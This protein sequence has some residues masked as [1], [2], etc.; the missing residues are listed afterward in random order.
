M[1]YNNVAGKQWNV[2]M[3]F[4]LSWLVGWF[5]LVSIVNAGESQLQDLRFKTLPGDRLQLQFQFAGP[6]VTP[7]AFQTNNPARI[8]LDFPGVKSALNKKNIPINMGVVTHVNIVEGGGRSRVVIN[9]IDQAPYQIEPEGN[10]LLVTVENAGAMTSAATPNKTPSTDLLGQRIEKIDFRRGPNGEG[11]I[12][13]SLENPNTLVD[14]R[15]EGGKVIATFLNTTLPRKLAKKLDVTDF[16]TPVK[17]ISAFSD[18]KKTRLVII[19]AGGNYDYLSYQSNRLLTIEFRPLSR[20]EKEQIKK[21]KFP[22]TGQRLSLNFQDIPVRSVLQILADF[23]GLNIIAS[24]SVKGNVTLRLNNVPWDQ[25]LDLILK[26]KGLGKRKEGTV[27]WI[28]PLDEIIKLEK[29][30]LEHVQFKEK[31][32]PLRTEIIQLNYAKAAAVMKV[33]KGMQKTAGTGETGKIPEYTTNFQE[34]SAGSVEGTVA[35]GS[36]LSPRGEVNI[37]PRTN[38]LIVKDTPNNLE[39]VRKLVHRLDR[40]I[41]QVLIESRVVLADNNFTRELGIKINAQRQTGS[42]GSQQSAIGGSLGDTLL[43][44]LGGSLVDLPTTGAAAGGF[45][46]AIF[47]L[48]DYLMRL[49]ISALQAENRGDVIS[50]PKVITQDQNKASIEQGVEIPFATTSQNGTQTQFKEAVLKLDVTPHVTPDDN[51]VMDLLVKKDSQ[52]ITTPTGLISINKR[53]IETTVQVSNGET[54]VL[55]GVYEQEKRKTVDKVPFFGDL[56]GIGFFFRRV[57]NI[58]NKNE[59]LIF[60]TPKILKQAVT[61][62]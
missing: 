54:V 41:R 59:L 30:E 5:L 37:D 6:V 1:F 15:E 28:A 3:L 33:L 11:R 2:R 4:H 43:S 7:K 18:G 36:I 31:K 19:P 55:G 47:K 12:L 52:G 58:D 9:L 26:A 24:D 48:N 25:A 50:M 46:L 32:E 61:L 23:T 53:Q 13:I 20:A 60:I 10:E 45:G 38:I 49:E 29:K 62:H 44:Q 35:G 39:A 27:V 16:A 40:P 42:P 14:L 8:V 51:V 34:P 56:P 17:S 57:K 21:K 22:Y